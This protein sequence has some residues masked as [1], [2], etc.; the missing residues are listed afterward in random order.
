MTDTRAAAE[1]RHHSIMRRVG[2][3]A[4]I[5]RPLRDTSWWH[6]W[7]AER[8]C[9]KTLGHC[10]HPDGLVDWWCCECSAE[11]DGMPKH[12]CTVCAGERTG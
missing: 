5:A 9:R 11:T 7:R 3:G 10:W 1:G 4:E 12:E 2:G 8:A 6:R